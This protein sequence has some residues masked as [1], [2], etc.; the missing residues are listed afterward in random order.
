MARHD[1][2]DIA[3]I[4][5]TPPRRYWRTAF[6]A[7]SRWLVD[8]ALMG[9][10]IT[11]FSLRLPAQ[12]YRAYAIFFKSAFRASGSDGIATVDG[13]GFL[14]AVRVPWVIWEPY[15]ADRTFLALRKE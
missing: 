1:N 14:D 9:M 11:E 5:A 8:Y 4:I 3:A 7:I 6:I 15:R 10:R 12:S 13:G 2:I